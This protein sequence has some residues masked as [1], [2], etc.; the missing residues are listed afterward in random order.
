MLISLVYI[1]QS[2]QCLNLNQP[3]LQWVPAI[4]IPKVKQSGSETGHLHVHLVPN[5]RM[6]GETPPLPFMSLWLGA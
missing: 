1:V 3:P 2:I 6:H 4:F 5:F